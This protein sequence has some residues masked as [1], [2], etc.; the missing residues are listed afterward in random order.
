MSKSLTMRRIDDGTELEI[1]TANVIGEVV[2]AQTGRKME[3]AFAHLKILN[4]WEWD[5]RFF[6][7]A[8]D[9]TGLTRDKIVEG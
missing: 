4:V 6:G 3:T 8:P 1:G 9:V 5:G 2:R 7:N